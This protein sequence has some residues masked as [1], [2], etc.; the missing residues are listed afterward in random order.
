M[1]NRTIA[2]NNIHISNKELYFEYD[3]VIKYGRA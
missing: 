2:E 3:E 1:F